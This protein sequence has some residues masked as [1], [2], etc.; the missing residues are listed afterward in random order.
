MATTECAANNNLH[1]VFSLVR[2]KSDRKALFMITFVLL[3][4]EPCGL[5]LV[6]K[7]KSQFTQQSCRHRQS[8]M[9]QRNNQ[10]RCCWKKKKPN[11]L[12]KSEE[13]TND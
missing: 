11:L 13:M 10:F 6:L 12:L 5:T 7:A 2:V 4:W 1:N 8:E 3:Q 9:W